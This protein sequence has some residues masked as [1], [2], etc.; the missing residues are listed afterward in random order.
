METGF[1]DE[2]ICGEGA[3]CKVYRMRRNG[4][5][6]AVKRL[7]KELV[8]KPEYVSS[9]RKEFQIGQRLKHDALPV[10]RELKVDFE[11]VYIV[12]DFV[13]GWSV[14]EFIETPEGKDYFSSIDNVRR[15]LTELVNV[16]VYLH[17]SGVIHCD[18]KPA[19]IILRNSDRSVMVLDFDKAYSDTLNNTH[20]GT[21]SMSDPLES[22]QKPTASKDFSAI[23]QIVDYI[24][25][26]A[27][28][29]PL[30]EFKQFRKACNDC[31]VSERTLLATLYPKN[32][33]KYFVAV[34]VLI[35]LIAIPFFMFY[36]Q[37][38]TSPVKSSDETVS[39]VTPVSTVLGKDT[40]VV[41]TQSHP[42]QIPADLYKGNK[43]KSLTINIDEEMA[44]FIVEVENAQK[45]L[46]D[47]ITSKDISELLMNL[48]QSQLNQYGKI[49]NDCKS[50]YPDKSAID[51]ELDVA[52][53]WENS[54]ACQLYTKLNKAIS[55]TI[56]KRELA[57]ELSDNLQ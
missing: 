39:S 27:P 35:V 29:F 48:S 7:R 37:S 19:N 23:A 9:Y 22:N 51:V 11:E 43:E 54:K 21:P 38:D 25:K 56:K 12:M 16:V 55:D 8:D 36:N 49:V 10:Y 53:A 3:S 52:R 4:L 18:L 14:E 5:L 45:A 24:A 2:N 50:K 6:V 42:N 34:G 41:F 46:K 17:R 13:D 40:V 31:H 47:G 32:H 30:S 20:G 26:L 28:G 57:K 15:F 1:K 33:A 44:D